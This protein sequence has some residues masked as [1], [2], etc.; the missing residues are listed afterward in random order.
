MPVLKGT[1][2]YT[3]FLVK[4]PQPLPATSIVEKLNMFRFRSLHPHGEDNESMGWCAYLSEY[5]AEKTIVIN[6]FQYDQNLVL[7]MRV[8]NITLPKGLLRSFI[9]KALS[10]YAKEHNK[11]PDR[12]IKKEIELAE[13]L[14]LRS[15]VFP[16]IKIVESI[17]CQTTQELRVFSRSKAQIDRFLDL[18]QNTFLL[19]PERFDFA[20]SS[21]QLAQKKNNESDLEQMSHEPLFIPPARIDVQ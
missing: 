2:G 15:R 9:K 17:W 14:S 5:D 1:M 13:T 18:F 19:R 21:W 12:T 11:L 4:C 3:R 7:C 16:S 20:H 8:D 6:D 10:A